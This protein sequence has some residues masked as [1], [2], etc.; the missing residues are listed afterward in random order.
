[1]LLW[2][3]HRQNAPFVLA[4]PAG[5]SVAVFAHALRKAFST[6]NSSEL[7]LLVWMLVPMATVMYVHLPAKFLVPVAPAAAILVAASLA[8]RPRIGAVVL[9]V[10]IVSGLALGVAILRADQRFAGFGRTVAQSLIA[11]QVARGERVWFNG[12][13][14][15]QWYAELA[16]AQC[17]TIRAPFPQPG[18]IVYSAEHSESLIAL[19]EMREFKLIKRLQDKTPGGRILSHAHG[20]GFYSNTWGYLPWAWGSDAIETINIYRFAP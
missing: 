16:G 8:K 10:T 4:L 12:H 11:P 20:A 3:A 7:A 6:R 13:W 19:E 9:T 14:G 5:L 18:D 15:F 17:M 2:L 1:M